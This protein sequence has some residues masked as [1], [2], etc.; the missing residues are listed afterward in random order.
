MKQAFLSILLLLFHTT[1]SFAADVNLTADDKV[2]WHQKKQ[3]IVAVGN[4]VATKEDMTIKADSLTGY[5]ADRSKTTKGKSQITRVEAVGNVRMK[6][7]KASA[8]GDFMDYNLVK[9][10][11]VLKGSPAKITTD[12]ETITADGTITYYPTEQKAVAVDNVVASDSQN[13]IYTDKMIAYFTQET[14]NSSNLVMKEVQIEGAVRIKTPNAEV[15]AERG[16][17]LPQKGKIRLYDNIVINQEGNI[18]KGDIAE[19][20]LNSG[21]SKLLSNSKSGKVKGVFKE[22]KKSKNTSAEKK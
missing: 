20:D 14:P 3:K 5:Y 18:L 8:F 7:A 15:T 6:S 17:Y 1:V 21:I 10:V 13:K 11:A 4:A 2:E 16:T 22:K 9:D 12:K 19:T